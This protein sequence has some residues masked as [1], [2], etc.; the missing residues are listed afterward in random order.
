MTTE[1]E[2]LY[3][4]DVISWEE[5]NFYSRE[6]VTIA[7]SQTVVLGSILQDAGGGAYEICD[8]EADALAIALAPVTTGSG[9]T[10]EIPALVREAKVLA[11]GLCY[12]CLC[13]TDV[14]AALKAL[15]IVV[16][17]TVD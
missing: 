11:D 1:T 5:D 8:C 16:E 2:G 10:A 9:E 15:G 4:S 12:L 7:A 14:D 3:P 13:K 17:A 6:K